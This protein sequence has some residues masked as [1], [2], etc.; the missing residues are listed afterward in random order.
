MIK[1]VTVISA[2]GGFDPVAACEVGVDFFGLA[3]CSSS[4]LGAGGSGMA[5]AASTGVG[6]AAGGAFTAIG[7]AML[8][9]G[10]C[11]AGGVKVAAET[12]TGAAAAGAGAGA[13]VTVTVGAADA[14]GAGAGAG[15]GAFGGAAI[16]MTG[17][18][19]VCGCINRW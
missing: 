7:S 18:V 8:N 2:V 5:A 11:V 9:S 12:G 13:T 6:S 17:F 16:S 1:I 3:G 14:T 4:C 10:R 15:I 19:G